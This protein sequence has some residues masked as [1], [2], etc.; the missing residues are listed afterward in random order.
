MARQAST[1]TA[2]SASSAS[3]AA[4]SAGSVTGSASAGNSS[5]P[6]IS[7]ASTN[8]TA[9]PLTAIVASQATTVTKPL[10]STPAAGAQPTF[11]PGAP[12]LPD[13]STLAPSKYPPLDQPPPVDSPEVKEWIAEVART[14]IVIPDISPTVD[15]GCPANAAAAADK[16]RCWW[17]CTGC[18]RSTDIT[19][20]PTAMDW[21]LTYDDGPGF[22]TPNLLEYLDSQKLKSTFFVVGSRVVQFPRTLQYEYMSQHQIAVHTWSHRP[23]TEQSNVQIIAELGWSRKVIKDV[24]GVTPNAMRPP[25]GDIDDRV[26]AISVAMGL[27][28]VIWTRLSPQVTFDTDDFNIH[29]G[30]TS[31]YKVLQNWKNILGNVSTINTGFVVLEHDLFQE[32]VEVATGYI[33]P[34]A[35]AHNPPFSIKP[36]SQCVG[37]SLSDAYIETNNNQTHPPA[38]EAA[39]AG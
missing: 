5:V 25:F 39:L 27:T 26:R 8:P 36:V 18:T 28:P 34:D 13:I 16:N 17:T 3:S 1:T 6:S 7:L 19:S 38:L 35:L 37:R 9:V 14:G 15:G 11:I 29:N 23:L 22:Y 20:C 24:L 32:S 4:S 31:V 33:L 10:P 21:G 12:P 2:N 30:Q